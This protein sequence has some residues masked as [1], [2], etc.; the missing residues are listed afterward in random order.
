MPLS[1]NQQDDTVRHFKLSS[2]AAAALAL[3]S[4]CISVPP[5]ANKASGPDFANVQHA[6]SIQLP[7]AA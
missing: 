5:D 6:P 3:L 2:I 4:G 1:N 7:A